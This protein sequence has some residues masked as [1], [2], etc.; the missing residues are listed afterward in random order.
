[1]TGCARRQRVGLVT[2]SRAVQVR[3]SEVL[4]GE[5]PAARVRMRAAGA[6]VDARPPAGRVDAPALAVSRVREDGDP[7]ALAGADLPP[8]SRCVPVR[9][10]WESMD[11]RR[12][13]E[14]GLPAPSPPTCRSMSRAL[15]RPCWFRSPSA[16]MWRG[17]SA[18][19]VS[20]TNGRCSRAL[21]SPS[22][23]NPFRVHAILPASAGRVRNR[24]R[25]RQVA[26]RMFAT[27]PEPGAIR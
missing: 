10:R 12:P 3:A 5:G 17:D 14:S 21:G 26:T 27:I 13:P 23:R 24:G 19:R 16:E 18:Y 1:M 15:Q 7:P 25:R 11:A 9:E 4:A 8:A 22:A 2:A 20:A 6:R